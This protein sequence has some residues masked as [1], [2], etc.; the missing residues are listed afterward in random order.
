MSK[1]VQPVRFRKDAAPYRLIKR[2]KKSRWLA[3]RIGKKQRSSGTNCPQ[4]ARAFAYRWI[5]S[6]FPRLAAELGI[7]TTPSLPLA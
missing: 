2:G 7:E 3:V 1:A 6:D 5:A 4:E